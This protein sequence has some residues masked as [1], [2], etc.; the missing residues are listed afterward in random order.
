MGSVKVKPGDVDDHGY[1][2]AGIQG[3]LLTFQ[4]IVVAGRVEMRRAVLL[5]LLACPAQL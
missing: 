3:M 2:L 1:I 4:E 5:Y